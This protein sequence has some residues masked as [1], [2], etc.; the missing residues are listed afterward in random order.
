MIVSIIIND[1]CT[2]AVIW[3]AFKLYLICNFLLCVIHTSLKQ[4]RSLYIQV[5]IVSKIS[6]FRQSGSVFFYSW[7]CMMSQAQIW[8][9][10][11]VKWMLGQREDDLKQEVA[12]MTCYRQ[13]ELNWGA[14]GKK[15]RWADYNFII[16]HLTPPMCDSTEAAGGTTTRPHIYFCRSPNM[17]DFTCWWHPLSNL[18]DGEEVTHILTYSKEYELHI[19]QLTRTEVNSRSRCWLVALVHMFETELLT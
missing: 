8:P 1:F 16:L 19:S 18:T 5:F 14:C 4:R 6:G 10:I 2:I 15:M 12:K 7:L 9:N 3:N 11:S 13:N 17:E